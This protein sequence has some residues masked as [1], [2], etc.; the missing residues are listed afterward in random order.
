M[1]DV[2]TY[3]PRICG[4]NL[5]SMK[6]Y[7]ALFCIC[8]LVVNCSTS[9][10]VDSDELKI[11]VDVGDVQVDGTMIQIPMNVKCVEGAKTTTLQI[12]ELTK[13]FPCG[14]TQSFEYMHS[15]PKEE[16]KERR[17]KK[18]NYVLRARFFHEEKKDK[19]LTQVLVV[20][21]YKDYQAKLEVHQGMTSMKNMDGTFSDLLAHGQCSEG[22][23]VELE[24][25]DDARGVSLEEDSTP[26]SETGFSFATRRPGKMKKGMRLLI[27][28]IKDEKAI[29]SY[30]VVLFN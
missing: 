12:G 13:T 11:I 9:K 19:T 17:A 27:R 2:A 30:E 26:C 21:S 23:T 20:V 24:V 3:T 18:S 7:F 10:K 22:S 29:A 4:A 16:M 1:F 25:F 14:E 28:Q 8:S 5:N 6:K 15:F